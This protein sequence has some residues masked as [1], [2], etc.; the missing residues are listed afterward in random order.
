MK[1]FLI[2][3]FIL[4]LATAVFGFTAMNHGIHDGNVTGG[5]GIPVLNI[6]ICA[7]DIVGMVVHHIS[8]YQSF[9]QIL[10]SHWQTSILLFLLFVFTTGVLLAW[11]RF[12]NL[13]LKHFLLPVFLRIRF[14]TT[15]HIA[16]FKFLNWLSLFENSPP[17]RAV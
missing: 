2:I 8:A 11:H 3:F 17:L 13:Q 12:L 6:S 4:F 15:K 1:Y 14:Q 7:N 5:C 16:S 9:S 10:V